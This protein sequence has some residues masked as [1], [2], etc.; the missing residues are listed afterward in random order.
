MANEQSTD[1]E[2]NRIDVQQSK[3]TR[4]TV[5]QTMGVGGG[6]IIGA[7]VVKGS[8]KKIDVPFA[9]NRGEVKKYVKVNADW[10]DHVKHV[11][12]VNERRSQ[13]VE[14][15]A[16]IRSTGIGMSEKQIGGRNKKQINAHHKPDINPEEN[17]DLPDSIEGVEVNYI[18]AEETTDDNCPL[19][20][21]TDPIRGG[22][23]V[24][25]DRGLGTLTCSMKNNLGE[26]IFVSSAHL[27]ADLSGDCTQ[28]PVGEA[29]YQSTNEDRKI[30]EI[31]SYLP[32]YDYAEI[33]NSGTADDWSQEVDLLH[34]EY[35]L[36][37]FVLNYAY[38]QD[39]EV[40]L[41]RVGIST[42]RETGHVIEY[43]SSRPSSR[44]NYMPSYAMQTTHLSAGGD[45]GGPIVYENE[46]NE[47]YLAGHH[48]SSP[49][50]GAER[51]CQRNPEEDKAGHSWCLQG[52]YPYDRGN[53]FD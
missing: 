53:Y 49:S 31:D 7:P 3:T 45:S 44:C 26:D 29:A 47:H 9:G 48:V 24:N 27:W 5:L 19:V 16:K 14:E 17:N 43:D 51:D 33:D 35:E 1:E 25:G 22:Y 23:V 52:D 4:R 41:E 21:E 42:N 28:D 13:E 34:G 46:N 8:D 11:E 36:T 2:K 37:H 50:D 18:P 6:L 15:N 30:G 10:W 38:L 40:S 20:T 32:R 39:E 12:D